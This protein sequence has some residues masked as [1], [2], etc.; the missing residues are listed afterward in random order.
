MRA[1]LVLVA[2]LTPLMASSAAAK[3]EREAI[4]AAEWRGAAKRGG[5]SPDVIKAQVL[6][7]RA[8]F[9]P[10]AI[11]GKAG[12][13]L[14]KAIAA[15]ATAERL[16]GSRMTPALWEALAATSQ[17]P[18]LT[19]YV[20]TERDLR[21][22]FAPRIPAKME[23]MDRLPAL[24]Y[25]N[26]R[27]MLAER[28][29]M[30][31][32]LLTL[33]NPGRRLDVAGETITVANV[34]ADDLPRKA[35]RVEIDKSAQTLRAFDR[36]G[37]LLAFYPVTVGSTERPA[38]VGTLK[39]TRIAENPTYTYDPSL[40]FAGVRTREPFTIQ[41]GPNNPV[42]LVWIALSEKGYGIHGTPDPSKISKSE[43]H[44]CIRLTNWDALEL[45]SAVGKGTPV[46]LIGKEGARGARAQGRPTERPG[47]SRR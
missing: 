42:G 40:A 17:K 44:G 13:N 15:F 38:P 28:F 39:V 30:T 37:G 18:I 22:P 6:L 11:D 41:P 4:E 10:G 36:E 21:G 27:E 16:P 24:S 35:A 9:S 1:T 8:R 12:E 23:D 19:D 33:L 25:R 7:D 29:H 34:N 32:D 45:V 20:V 14:D 5:V 46:E 47:R 43:S 31:E 26:P 3:L 2:V